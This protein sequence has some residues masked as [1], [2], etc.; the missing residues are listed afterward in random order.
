[1]VVPINCEVSALILFSCI[2]G[3]VAAQIY[4]ELCVIY[5]LTIMSEEEVKQWCRDFK[6]G[7][8]NVR[9]EEQYGRPSIQTR[10]RATSVSQTDLIDD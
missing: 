10:N 3:S 2:K 8:T 9:D 6:S 1:M 5:G 4:Q 7:H